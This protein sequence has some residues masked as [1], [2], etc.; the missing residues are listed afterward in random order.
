MNFRLH[1]LPD[2]VERD[3]SRLVIFQKNIST[4]EEKK[5]L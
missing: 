3:S 4:F 2:Y 5:L 1:F